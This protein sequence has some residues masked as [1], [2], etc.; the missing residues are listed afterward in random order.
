MSVDVK[1]F[2]WALSDVLGEQLTELHVGTCHGL[3]DQSGKAIKI[4]AIMNDEPHNGNFQDF[5]DNVEGRGK[6]VV[7]VEIW[8]KHLRQHLL[9]V[10]GYR[11]CKKNGH[12]RVVKEV[13]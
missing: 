11:P 2:P 13:A 5:M 7:V 9:K 12:K 3:I 8:N 10:R 6:A 1:E 4:I